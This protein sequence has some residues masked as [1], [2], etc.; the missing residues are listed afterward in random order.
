[1]F[2]NGEKEDE[3]SVESLEYESCLKQE[4]VLIITKKEK[5][6]EEGNYLLL[7]QDIQKVLNS[8]GFH[9]Y[10]PFA[11]DHQDD[12]DKMDLFFQSNDDNAFKFDSFRHNNHQDSSV[13]H[14]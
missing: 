4:I 13:S 11:R 5:K 1:M 9:D 10:P 14:T 12:D 7:N 3:I 6:H 8:Q 2:S